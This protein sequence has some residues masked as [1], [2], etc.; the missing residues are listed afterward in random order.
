MGQLANTKDHFVNIQNSK[1]LI[2]GVTML[3]GDGIPTHIK[4]KNNI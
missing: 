2:L 1:E 3:I 4:G